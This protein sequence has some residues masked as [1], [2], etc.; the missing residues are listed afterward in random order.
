MQLFQETCPATLKDVSLVRRALRHAL[1]EIRLSDEVV[2]DLQVL[3]SEIAVNAIEH[4]EQK[5]TQFEVKVRIRGAQVGLEIIDDASP[6]TGFDEKYASSLPKMTEIKG[7]NTAL[8][9]S[10]RGIGLV[11]DFA[12]SVNYQA[13]P[14]NHFIIWRDLNKRQP[15]VLIVED[16]RVLAETYALGL[17]PTYK[18]IIADSVEEALA[19]LDHTPVDLVVAD[20]HL[21]DGTGRTLAET[22]ELYPDRLPVPVI[23]ITGDRNPDVQHEMLEIGVEACLQKPVS[24]QDLHDNIRLSMGRAER[25]RASHFR[26]FAAAASKLLTPVMPSNLRDFH[27]GHHSKVADLGSGDAVLH[28]IGENR[29]RVILMDVMGH[30]LGAHSGAIAL[31]AIARA[32]HAQNPDCSPDVFLTQISKALY[33]DVTL[34]E[35]IATILVIDLL[36]EGVIE[37]SSAGHPPPVQVGKKATQQIDVH[38]PLPGFAVDADYEC[39]TLRLCAGERLICFTDGLDP[40]GLSAGE[41]LPDWLS[42]AFITAANLSMDEGMTAYVKA[43][44]NVVGP[45]PEDDWTLIALEMSQK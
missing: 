2:S 27:L 35:L 25:R 19:T 29:D 44:Q 5:P 39:Q 15:I 13:G 1:T 36:E 40:I 6:F 41:E 37:I 21:A 23:L 26:H 4:S 18:T 10:G 9:A 42:S 33:A 28:L 8:T 43:I 17:Y 3:L 20:Y 31:A 22:M 30:G 38:G 16:E 32:I 12:D 24:K 11:R 7:L 45:E 34:G 14:P